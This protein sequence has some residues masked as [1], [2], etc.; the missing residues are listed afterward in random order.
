MSDQPDI[1]DVTG[2]DHG[3]A[4]AIARVARAIAE[5]CAEWGV[6]HV[7]GHGIPPA[8]LARFADAMRRLFELPA[9]RS[10]VAPHA[11]QR[12]GLVRRRAHQEP[13]RLEGGV[14][15]RRRARAGA[16]ARRTATA[17]TAGPSLCPSCA[18]RC[19]RTTTAARRSRAAYC[20]RSARA[21]PRARR[22]RRRVHR[23]HELP[24]PEPLPPLPR[25][26][27]GRRLALAPARPARGAP[28]H[29]RGRG[30]AALAGRARGPPGAARRAARARSSPCRTRSR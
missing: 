28:P 19:S 18:R 17:P 3:G 14:R 29:R 12:L 9:R 8:E 5:P 30:H 13:A 1:I 23:T 27:A 21:R 10:S 6:F 26:R 16:P 7:V 20:T 4:G 25:P 24:A 2:L 15:L 11:R 22:A